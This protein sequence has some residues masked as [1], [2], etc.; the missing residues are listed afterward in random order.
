MAHMN[1]IKTKWNKLDKAAKIFPAASSRAE[2]HVFRF[3]CELDAPID[4]AQLQAALDE[5]ADCFPIFGYVLHRGIFWYYLEASPLTPVVEEEHKPLCAPLY[6]PPAR[7]LLYKVS[8]YEATINLEVYHV[9][10]DGTGAMHF[11]RTLVMKYLARVHGLPE[12]NL[13]YETAHTSMADDSFHRYS[14]PTRT[15]RQPMTRAYQLRGA[16]LSE[17]RT[18]LIRGTM[19]TRAL[20]DAAH[21]AGVTMTVYLTACLIAAIGEGIPLRARKKPVV[22]NIPVNLR[23]YFASDSVRNF[24]TPIYISYNF[25]RRDGS[26][27]DILAEVSAIFARELERDKLA[28]RF[29]GFTAFE[30]NF[31]ARITPL[32]LKD[33]VMRA[34][35]AISRGACTGTLSNVGIVRMPDTFAAHIRGFHV[36]N[37]TNKIQACVC[38]FGDQLS[39]SM[40]SSYTDTDIRRRFFRR[41]RE[42]DPKLVIETNLLD[43]D[44]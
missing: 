1:Q 3:S 15:E 23:N 19:R 22:L 17:A 25:A 6:R 32:Y 4:P 38:S 24:F 9:L 21:E 34:V 18:G 14:H 13:G 41:L 43:D 37:A 44:A 40:T 26:F 33:I 31:F 16:K 20:L 10:T 5:T 11:L 30:E 35:Y 27:A 2:T 28:A 39:I 42:L 36:C 8:Y 7:T 12:E 29:N